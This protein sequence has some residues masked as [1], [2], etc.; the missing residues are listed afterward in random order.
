MNVNI[1]AEIGSVHD[2]SF[3]NA[4][5]FI[6]LVSVLGCDTVKFQL[7]IPE[8]ETLKTAPNP[9]YFKGE[10]RF[11]YFKRTAFSISQWKELV[12]YAHEKKLKFSCSPFSESALEILVDIGVD[13]IKVASGEVSNLP[14]LRQIAQ[15][16]REVHL[17]S[18]MSNWNELDDAVIELK[19]I[20]NLT[21]MQ[22]SSIYPTPVEK[23]GLNI[24]RDLKSRYNKSI[25]FSDHTSSNVASLAAV[26]FGATV[27]EKHLTF[28]KYMYGSDALN[29]A[30]PLQ[31]KELVESIRELS[32]ILN[33][34]VDKNDLAPYR[35]M[36]LI[37]EK[38]MVTSKFIPIGTILD[39]THIYFKKPGNGISA[40]R[41]RNFIGKRII[42]NLEA[43]HMIKEEDFE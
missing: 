24:L 28:S 4:K 3:G 38:S 19:N 26:S 25:G 23:V 27:I 33:A 35:D 21:V 32:R 7:H 34:P 6:N 20:S 14:L 42:R 5:Q 31:F 30:E 40:K 10:T 43:D 13:I 17:S 41:S 39:E 18:G 22:C 8:S 12:N 2:G 1:V 11:E 37:F 9:P 15:C 29:A 16:N 36:K